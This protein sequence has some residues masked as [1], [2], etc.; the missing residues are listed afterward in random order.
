MPYIHNN[1]KVISDFVPVI[2]FRQ[3][4]LSEHKV[5]VVIAQYVVLSVNANIS[6]SDCACTFSLH[7]Q[8]I[9][10][11]AGMEIDMKMFLCF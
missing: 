10:S 11:S 4:L 5:T 6:I 7:C 3:L 9:C 8:S 1:S 2:K